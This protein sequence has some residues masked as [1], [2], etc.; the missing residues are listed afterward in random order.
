MSLLSHAQGHQGQQG[1]GYGNTGNDSGLALA[2]LTSSGP[3]GAHEGSISNYG[4]TSAVVSA[5]MPLAPSSLRADLAGADV[6]V[7]AVLAAQADADD[8]V[9][10]IAKE[11]FEFLKGE[12]K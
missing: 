9:V 10:P 4:G 1:Q 2:A 3:S 6:S 7:D 11:I 5:A 8:G 12:T